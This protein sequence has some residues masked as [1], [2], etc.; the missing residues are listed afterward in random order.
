[1]ASVILSRRT[2]TGRVAGW[3][4]VRPGE[5]RLVAYLALVYLVLGL[6]MALGHSSSEA[7]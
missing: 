7:L 4:L 5:G 3:L 1:M 6:G 2:A